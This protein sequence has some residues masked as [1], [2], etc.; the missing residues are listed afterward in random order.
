MRGLSC[1]PGRKRVRALAPDASIQYTGGTATS[2][3]MPANRYRLYRREDIEVFLASLRV[4]NLRPGGHSG[5][6]PQTLRK[7]SV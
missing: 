2:R 4:H 6:H 5:E 7:E 3:T 1:A